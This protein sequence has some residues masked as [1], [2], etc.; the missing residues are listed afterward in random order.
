MT[1]I[2]PEL[3]VAARNSAGDKTAS[4]NAHAAYIYTK[5]TPADPNTFRQQFV[6]NQWRLRSKDWRDWLTPAQRRGWTLYAKNTPVGTTLS[7]PK[8]ITGMAHYMRIAII[9]ARAGIPVPPFAPVKFGLPPFLPLGFKIVNGDT[10]LGVTWDNS[11]A[12]ADELGS[13]AWIAVTDQHVHTVNAF[14]PPYVYAGSIPGSAM[15]PSTVPVHFVAAAGQRIFVR[16]Q[17]QRADLRL[18]TAQHTSII[19]RTP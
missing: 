9:R 16:S 14:Q 6:R 17:I 12:W 15:P 2:P 8:Y 1:V 5:V 13:Y 19:V 3:I 11:D 7:G 18:S 4:R 10:V